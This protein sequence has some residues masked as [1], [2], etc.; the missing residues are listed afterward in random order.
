MTNG[1]AA[2]DGAQRPDPGSVAQTAKRLKA[3]YSAVVYDIMDEMGLPHQCLDLA[4][5]PLDRSMQVAGPAYTVAAA[6]DMRERAEMPPNTKLADFGVFTHMY[7]GCVVAAAGERQSGIWGELMS[8]ASR[9][10]GATGVVID[11]GIR[12]GRLVREIDGLSVF[13][14]YTSP[15][16]SL[17]RSRI[18]DI[19]VPIS[20]TGTL[21]SQVRVDP[22]DWIFGD[23]DGVLVIPKDA[24]NEVLAKSEEAKDV[25]DKVREEVQSGIPV[26][27]VYHKY[28]RL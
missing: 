3:L 20:M 9:A 23:E 22:G 24:L 7:D 18:H 12:D 14:R 8:N 6:P 13:A 2:P 17:R 25:E 26:I 28:G 15:I 4:V 10:R 19:E 5:A 1:P 21:T 16:E 27:D 11:G